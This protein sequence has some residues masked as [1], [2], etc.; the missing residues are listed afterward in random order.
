MS[1]AATQLASA[2][3][4]A[5]DGSRIQASSVQTTSASIEQLNASIA[6]NADHGRA[7]EELARSDAVSAATSGEAVEQTVAS[8]KLI[9]ARVGVIDDIAYQ[10]NIL[11]LNAA[12]KSR[13]RWRARH[14]L[15]GRG[16]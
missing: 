2:V 10:T 15:R 9:A 14:G 7:T 16:E 12:I 3:E 13:P 1:A 11:A 5:S 8:M 6:Q 4:R